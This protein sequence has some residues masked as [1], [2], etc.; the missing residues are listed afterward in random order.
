MIDKPFQLQ[1]HKTW[2]KKKKTGQQKEWP[3]YTT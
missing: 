3:K 1:S 2:F